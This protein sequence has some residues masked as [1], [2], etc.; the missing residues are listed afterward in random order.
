[1]GYIYIKGQ[2]NLI[3][4]LYS[5]YKEDFN[6]YHGMIFLSKSYIEKVMTITYWFIGMDYPTKSS[7][8]L[9][10]CVNIQ[11]RSMDVDSIHINSWN[12]ELN[13]KIEII[14]TTRI[15]LQYKS[16]WPANLSRVASKNN[17]TIKIIEIYFLRKKWYYMNRV[18]T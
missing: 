10:S 15:L 16:P 11:A 6:K 12:N 13:R 1:M 2:C 5:H 18:F 14:L 7:V 8:T 4:Y 3:P 9:C 17:T